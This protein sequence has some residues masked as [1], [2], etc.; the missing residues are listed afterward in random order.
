MDHSIV[1]DSVINIWSSEEKVNGKIILVMVQRDKLRNHL[2]KPKCDKGQ[3]HDGEVHHIDNSE[4]Y[5]EQCVLHYQAW[6]AGE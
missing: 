4:L 3:M 2:K 5:L 1:Y 6:E